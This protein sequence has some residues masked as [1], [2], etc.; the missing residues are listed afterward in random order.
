MKDY[1]TRGLQILRD[2][3]V[4]S[5]T[6]SSSSYLYNLGIYR[7]I[8]GGRVRYYRLR[9]RRGVRDPYTPIWISPTDIKYV[10]NGTFNPKYQLGQIK[11]GDWDQDIQE[12]SNHPAFSGLKERFCDGK[13][14]TETEYFDLGVQRIQEEGVFVGYRS[15]EEFEDRLEYVEQLFHSIKHDGYRTQTSLSPDDWDEHR[16][17]FVTPAH[18]MTGE[19]G[20]NIGRDGTLIEN[21]GIHRLTIARILDLEEIPVQIIVRH[22]EWQRIRDRVARFPTSIDSE[23]QDHP[24]IANL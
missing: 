6:K 14:W 8:I 16:H 15:V 22:P 20:I 18:R 4:R 1:Y 13:P 23:M 7:I 24:D 19:I 9:G 2:E 11:G 21:D 12:L 17:P 5:L 10:Y 3:G